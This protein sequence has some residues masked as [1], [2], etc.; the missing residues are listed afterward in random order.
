MAVEDLLKIGSALVE[1]TRRCIKY[2]ENIEKIYD[3]GKSEFDLEID[4][5]NSE[6][7]YMRGSKVNEMRIQLEKKYK[8]LRGNFN[9]QYDDRKFFLEQVNTISKIRCGNCGEL[10]TLLAA[11]FSFLDPPIEYKNENIF[12]SMLNL[13]NPLN[14]NKSH[15]FCLLHQSEA[16]HKEMLNN[17]DSR[18]FI[19]SSLKGL[20]GIQNQ[21]AMQVEADDDIFRI[22][23]YKKI[24]SPLNL[25]ELSANAVIVDPWIY[26]ATKL[27]NFYEEHFTAA[28]EFGVES[29]YSDRHLV[30]TGC[31]PDDYSFKMSQNKGMLSD[32]KYKFDTAV[33]KLI[34]LYNQIYGGNNY[35]K[36][37][38]RSLLDVR[39]SF[40]ENESYY[41]NLK[42]L[43]EFVQKLFSKS[44]NYYSGRSCFSPRGEHKKDLCY[45]ILINYLENKNESFLYDR[46]NIK[47]IFG[48]SLKLSALIRGK[49]QPTSKGVGFKVAQTK[50]ACALLDIDVIPDSKYAFEQLEGMSLDKFR[51]LR[52]KKNN[53]IMKMMTD[54]LYLKLLLAI[55][56]EEYQNNN[57]QNSFQQNN[58]IFLYDAKYLDGL[59]DEIRSLINSF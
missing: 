52:K 36:N 26:K 14:W 57:Q 18:L 39:K 58:F 20:L 5:K 33:F 16:L 54:E 30:R 6:I 11:I 31:V 47:S 44:S 28:Q 8:A 1:V 53:T 23:N 59:Y 3:P 35:I 2:S 51:I 32:E 46:K 19:A 48:L 37:N 10:S 12:I 34:E 42:S 45:K 43:L 21:Q 27:S 4:D 22:F 25:K 56:G 40:D 15:T 13:F 7:F 38:G 17:T 49:S 41:F 55:Y 29:Y 50:T 9:F 24:Q